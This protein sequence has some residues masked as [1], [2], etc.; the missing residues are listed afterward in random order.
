MGAKI[1]KYASPSVIDYVFESDDI[2][3]IKCS[4]PKDFNDPYELFL[5]VDFNQPPE[6][7]AFYKEVI[8]NIPQLP[9]TCFSN[10]PEV[11]PM[12]AHYADNQQGFVIE[13]DEELL[14]KHFPDIEPGDVDYQDA[15]HEGLLDL[16]HRGYFIGKPRYVYL[17]QRGVFSAAYYT[18]Q[19][20]WSYELE[21]RLVLKSNDV[22]ERAGMM[23]LNIPMECVTSII[24]GPRAVP[25]TKQ[26][27]N[28]LC[29]N[30][31]CSHFNMIIGKSS[32]KPYFV[33]EKLEIYLFDGSSIA[34]ADF[35]CQECG[36]PVAEGA[37]TC[38]WCAIDKEHEYAASRGN[39]MRMLAQVGLLDDYYKSMNDV[40][41]SND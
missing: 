25:S 10:S 5:T 29:T 17:L 3:T 14:K 16:L 34:A 37:E 20:C 9:V 27:I 40:G 23:L 28:E 7:L 26:R 31:G 41:K 39:P 38:P 24:S 6:V 19:S 33:K 35:F 8:G 1:Y 21:R 4:L 36:E 15:P 13:F 2:C 32:T 30:A 12:W 11:V 22:V 18:K